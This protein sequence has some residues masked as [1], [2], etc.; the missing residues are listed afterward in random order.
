MD[1][2]AVRPDGISAVLLESIR[3]QAH[4][5]PEGGAAFGQ[6]D[7]TWNASALAI[8]DD[9]AD[10]DGAIIWARYAAERFGVGSL[11]GAG[12]ANY[13]PVDET[14]ERVRLSFGTERFARL[15]MVKAR[16][17]PNNTFRFNQNVAP[18]IIRPPQ[19]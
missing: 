12:Y 15:A 11:T 8:W 13:A 5:E 14:I 17:D 10:D 16:Y 7:A 1:A 3:G 6:R 9:P 4:R 18:A 19:D 2:L